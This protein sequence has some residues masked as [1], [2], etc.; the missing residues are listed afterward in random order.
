M[1]A[2]AQRHDGQGRLRR[3]P[4]ARQTRQDEGGK[5]DGKRGP[6]RRAACGRSLPPARALFALGRPGGKK[7]GPA[8]GPASR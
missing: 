5:D 8:P 4:K 1:A 7:T 3:R 6:P 2:H